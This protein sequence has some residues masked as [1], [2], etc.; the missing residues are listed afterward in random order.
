MKFNRINN[1][2]RSVPSHGQL[3]THTELDVSVGLHREGAET[4]ETA[5]AG[6]PVRPLPTYEP[7]PL[8]ARL[9]SSTEP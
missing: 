8:V 1:S 9:V 5:G 3:T 7:M 2:R 4:G 6:S